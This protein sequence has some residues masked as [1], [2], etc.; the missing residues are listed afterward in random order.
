MAPKIIGHEEY[1]HLIYSN[2]M[3][4]CNMNVN[5]SQIKG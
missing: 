4:F 2:N 1:N 3:I 5:I